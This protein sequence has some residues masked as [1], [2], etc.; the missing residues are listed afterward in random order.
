MYRQLTVASQAVFFIPTYLHTITCL[1]APLHYAFLP[2]S[3]Q[4]KMH[5]DKNPPE[6][7]AS[8]K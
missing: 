1:H 5:N 8:Y 2:S 4:R 6:Q 7:T 3:T